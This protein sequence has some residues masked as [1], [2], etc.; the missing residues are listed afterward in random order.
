MR[1]RDTH[2]AVGNLASVKLPFNDAQ[3]RYFQ[4]LQ[5]FL[6]LLQVA[7][8]ALLHGSELDSHRLL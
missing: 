3:G 4:Y 7:L 5:S 8:I 2:G 6:A 1:H